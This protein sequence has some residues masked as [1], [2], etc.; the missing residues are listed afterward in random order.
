M[1]TIHVL[2]VLFSLI[3]VLIA[4]KGAMAWMRGKEQLMSARR[5][6]LLHALTWTGLG[7]LIVSGSL[8][9]YP[10]LGYLLSQP[11]FIMKMLFVGVLVV[12]AILIGKLSAYAV[13]EPFSQL[14]H[15]DRMRLITSGAVSSFSWV[16][17]VIIALL[18]F[19]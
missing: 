9:A 11:L 8:I 4:D 14:T 3:V 17:I 5:V 7:V 6:R 12:N 15:H 18:F 16:A 2:A 10:M 19:K 13:R 1:V